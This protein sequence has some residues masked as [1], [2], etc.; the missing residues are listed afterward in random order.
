MAIW[1]LRQ[2]SLLR[3]SQQY[4]LCLHF[5][6]AGCN[7]GRW[8][9]DI[10]FPT[11]RILDLRISSPAPEKKPSGATHTRCIS[12]SPHPFCSSSLSPS[13]PTNALTPTQIKAWVHA[14]ITHKHTHTHTAL[15]QPSAADMLITL[16]SNK[17][18][19]FLRQISVDQVEL[20]IIAPPLQYP[21]PEPDE[22][23]MIYQ[24][25]SA[26]C[27]PGTGSRTNTKRNTTHTKH[28]ARRRELHLRVR[29]V[30]LITHMQ[31]QLNTCSTS[32]LL[33][34]VHKDLRPT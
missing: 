32:P 34:T 25:V 13:S 4:F 22:R 16:H 11:K 2:A 6:G 5:Q 18:N 10:R 15:N 20:L 3:E 7:L 8:H 9:T 29:S 30:D 26:V 31:P 28:T 14:D 24:S 23:S 1:C 27:R 19:D 17:T 21:T 33:Y 12:F